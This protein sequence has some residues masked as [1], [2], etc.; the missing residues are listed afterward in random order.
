VLKAVAADAT[1]P[2]LYREMVKTLAVVL[3]RLEEQGEI[4]A[5]RDAT[6]LAQAFFAAYAGSTLTALLGEA[7][8]KAAARRVE[9]H[10]QFLLG[11]AK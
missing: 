11:E 9:S 3:R 1:M 6:E 7:T 2:T 10:L 4:A 8:P 5:G